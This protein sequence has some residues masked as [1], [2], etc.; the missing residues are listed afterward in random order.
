MTPTPHTVLVV[1]PHADDVAAFCGGTI[2][3]FA[4]EGWKVV[5]VRVTDDCRDSVGLTVEETARRNADELRVAARILGVAEIE[6]LGFETDRL[7]DVPLCDLRERLVYQLR[8]HRPYAVFG[9]DP[10]G[11]YEGNQDHVR[12][13]QATEEAFWVAAFDL[14]HPEH[15]AEGLAPFSVC[16][17]WYFARQLAH[18]NRVEDVSATMPRRVDAL[19]AHRTM[20]TNLIQGYRLQLQTWG[21]RV[22][23]LDRAMTGDPRELVATFLQGQAKEVA[24]RNGLP[25]GTLAE[26]F[27]LSRFGGLEELFQGL[28]EPLPGAP[29]A[30]LREELDKVPEAPVRPPEKVARIFPCDID[31]KVRLMGHH[32]LCLGAFDELK[33]SALFQAGYPDL[34]ARLQAK[35]D[36]EVEA[37]YG[38]DLFC[39]Q[40]GYWSED[41]GRCTTGWRDK[42]SKDAAVLERLG[43]AT[44]QVLTLAEVRRRLAERVGPEGLEH[45][46][47]RGEWFCDFKLMGRCQRA[48]ER[49]QKEAR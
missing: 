20:L 1:S 28:S 46:C 49:L 9:F 43:I 45:F 10:E 13:A 3:K 19:C 21:R 7:A 37:V 44:G 36:L 25:H 16:E 30:P 48:Y 17:R 38:Y 24:A 33:D 32:F 27:R 5:L 29:P 23:W 31:R 15:V 4:D 34:L 35:P 41:E 12:V 14:H 6:E 18:P 42:L 47:G 2:A 39:Y 8:K 22:A 40:C 26:E 11:L